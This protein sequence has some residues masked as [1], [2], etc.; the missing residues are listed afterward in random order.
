V[1][2]IF[3]EDY[4]KLAENMVFNELNKN[5]VGVYYWKNAQQEEVDFIIKKKQKIIQA[6]QVCW[7]I[8]KVE[9]KKREVVA[10]VKTCKEF[11]LKEG[12]I[13]TED[14]LSEETIEGIKISYQPIWK[15][16]LGKS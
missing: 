16:L 4:G 15:W 10:L 13:L 6:I 9:T 12:L 8:G 5:D 2:F 11:K 7:D 1:A 3:S 14:T